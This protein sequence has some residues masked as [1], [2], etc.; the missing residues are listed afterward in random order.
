MS[1][2]WCYHS[3]LYGRSYLL[4]TIPSSH[5]SCV[6]YRFINIFN[7]DVISVSTFL[8]PIMYKIG[9]KRTVVYLFYF[10]DGVDH[11]FGN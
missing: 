1:F 2:Y 11:P 8:R 3:Y 7:V 6:A 4:I 5:V 9:S 10:V